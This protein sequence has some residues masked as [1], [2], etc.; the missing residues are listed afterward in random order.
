[1]S[2]AEV[3]R[4]WGVSREEALGTLGALNIPVAD[5]SLADD[6]ATLE[7]LDK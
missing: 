3:A 2:L 7:H 5:Y 1:M 6:L 4:A